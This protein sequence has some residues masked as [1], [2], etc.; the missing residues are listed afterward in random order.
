MPNQNAQELCAKSEVRMIQL[1]IQQLKTH[2]LK[3]LDIIRSQN[4][5]IHKPRFHLLF[6]TFGKSLNIL[7]ASDFPSVK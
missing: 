4:W 7:I 6:Y 2:F 3:L 1:S 5:R